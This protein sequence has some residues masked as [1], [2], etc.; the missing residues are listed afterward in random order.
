MANERDY[1]IMANEEGDSLDDIQAFSAYKAFVD[2]NPL[3]LKRDSPF[4]GCAWK[5][6]DGRIL[7]TFPQTYGAE[8][9]LTNFTDRRH[10]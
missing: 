6:N 1:F 3:G 8:V 4:A 9:S 2:E 5:G 10:E 7:E